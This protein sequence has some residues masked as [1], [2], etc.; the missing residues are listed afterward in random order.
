MVETRWHSP[1]MVQCGSAT[2]AIGMIRVPSTRN[3]VARPAPITLAAICDICL[4]P[5][6]CSDQSCCHCTTSLITSNS[7]EISGQRSS[8]PDLRTIVWNCWP[9]GLAPHQPPES[10]SLSAKLTN[11]PGNSPPEDL[12]EQRSVYRGDGGG[13]AELAA[14]NAADSDVFQQSR[15]KPRRIPPCLSIPGR[16][17]CGKIRLNCVASLP[18][19]FTMAGGP[20]TQSGHALSISLYSRVYNFVIR[21]VYRAWSFQK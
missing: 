20:V 15:R 12:S 17:I 9:A 10:H 7:F 21:V 2:L 14:M 4:L 18:F 3:A 13:E 11:Y 5:E 16:M 8:T 6:K 19:L 1:A